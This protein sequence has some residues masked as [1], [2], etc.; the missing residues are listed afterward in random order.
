MSQTEEYWIERMRR[1]QEKQ[2][3]QSITELQNELNIYYS[4]A[5]RRLIKQFE[6]T[7]EKLLRQTAEGITPSVADLYKLDTYW[8]LQ[9]ALRLELQKLGDKQEVLFSKKFEEAYERVWKSISFPSQSAFTQPS[10]E[11]AHQLIN[12]IWC[13]DG[14]NWSTR[15]WGNIDKLQENLN[16]AL[17]DCVITG[18]KTTELKHMLMEEFGVGYN[19]A[20]TIARTEIAHIQTQTAR[21]RYKNY[22]IQKVKIVADKSSRTCPQCAELDGKEYPIDATMPVPVHPRCRCCI[23]PVMDLTSKK[24]DSRLQEKPVEKPRRIRALSTPSY[25]KTIPV[26]PPT[27]EDRLQ[28]I[29][30]QFPK[31]KTPFMPSAER[32]KITHG[33]THVDRRLVE[34]GITLEDAQHYIDTAILCFQQSVDKVMY[35]SEDGVAV[36]LNNG[37]LAT[38]YPKNKFDNDIIKLIKEIKLLWKK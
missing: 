14:K 6:A 13:A 29:Q 19:R 11:N 22:G 25:S 20:D 36:T 8:K 37:G 9:G 2:A 34:R 12:S 35:V 28:R 17:V 32:P 33:G 21:E 16:D 27:D 23:V 30:E 10:I 3:T 26:K 38:A 5:M 18:K 4:K 24:E 15:V 31:Y 1:A 7:Y